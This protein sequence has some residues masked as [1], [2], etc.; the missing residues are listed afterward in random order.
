MSNK[1]GVRYIQPT[2]VEMP[3]WR[4]FIVESNLPERLAPL[5][6]LSRNI[7]W[8]WNNEARDLF[9]YINEK[10]WEA[11]EHNP[12]ILLEQVSYQRFRELEKDAVFTRMMDSTYEKFL[13]YLKE[14][15]NLAK[16]QIAYFSMEYGLHD[17][18]KIF[19]GGLGHSRRGLPERS[20]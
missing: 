16:P 6:E 15:E 20:Q 9:Q 14:R 3:Q 17:S 8:V 7:W 2:V 5:K 11:C 10:V 4:K 12:I 19:S 1:E 13:K 18:L